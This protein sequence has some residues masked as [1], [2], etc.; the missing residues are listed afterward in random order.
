[1]KA[2]RFDTHTNFNKRFSKK[3]QLK[4]EDQ[5]HEL[6]DL[7]LKYKIKGLGLQTTVIKY[8]G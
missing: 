8:Q 5:I 3:I 2:I 6:D 4:I 1:M 7:K